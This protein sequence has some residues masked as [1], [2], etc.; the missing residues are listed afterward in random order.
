MLEITDP[1]VD[2]EERG[3]D[4]MADNAEASGMAVDEIAAVPP[5]DSCMERFG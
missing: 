5:E 4:V 2:R 1:G 3:E